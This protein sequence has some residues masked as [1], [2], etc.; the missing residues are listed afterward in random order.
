VS[1]SRKEFFRQGFFTL[2]DTLLKGAG[3]V[4]PGEAQEPDS[5]PEKLDDSVPR[6]AT[7]DNGHCLARS[8]GCFSCIEQCE[9]QAITMVAGVGVKIDAAACVGCGVCYDVCP[10]TPKAI[11]LVRREDQEHQSS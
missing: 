4:Q 8:C 10:V 9:N 5:E 2:G 3:I 6:R 7:A 11:S 1:I